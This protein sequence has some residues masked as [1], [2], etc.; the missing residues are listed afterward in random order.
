MQIFGQNIFGIYEYSQGDI[1]YGEISLVL[2]RLIKA[3]LSVT[4]QER[5][6]VLSIATSS[7]QL[8]TAD[9]MI[10]SNPTINSAAL[11]I[12]NNTQVHTASISIE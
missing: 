3:F 9:I 10:L 2:D 12:S 4:S 5:F 1:Y 6:A 7:V 8:R 11:N